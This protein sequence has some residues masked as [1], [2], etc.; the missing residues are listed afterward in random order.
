NLRPLVLRHARSLHCSNEADLPFQRGAFDRDGGDVVR[1]EVARAYVLKVTY[2]VPLAVLIEAEADHRP[3]FHGHWSQLVHD[4][5]EICS[6]CLA[7]DGHAGEAAVGGLT[8]LKGQTC[9]GVV[10]WKCAAIQDVAGRI[11]PDEPER[12]PARVSHCELVK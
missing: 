2:D 12:V 6:D 3:Q 4:R 11:V 10:V 1:N 7:V 8:R 9:R 5:G